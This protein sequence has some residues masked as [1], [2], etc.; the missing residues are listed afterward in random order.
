MNKRPTEPVA[1]KPTPAPADKRTPKEEAEKK[2]MEKK[3]PFNKY[4]KGG[5][6]DGVARKGKTSTKRVVMAKGGKC[7]A[8]GGSVDGIAR[9]GKT[10][11]K[12]V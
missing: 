1:K 2:A 3:Y 11:G 5:S 8:K 4:A 12:V 6:V 7:Y 10:K 9:K